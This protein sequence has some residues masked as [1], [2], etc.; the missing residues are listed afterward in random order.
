MGVKIRSKGNERDKHIHRVVLIAMLPMLA[1]SLPVHAGTITDNF[2]SYAVG[3]TFPALQWSDVGAVLPEPPVAPLPSATVI[4][5]TDA[6]GNATQ[7]LSTVGALAASKGIFAPVPVSLNY[8]LAADVRVDRY[9]DHSDSTT[10][11]WA[12]QLTFAQV[13]I[14][15]F[16]TTPQAGIYASSLTQGWRLFLISSNGGAAFADI[17]LGAA[18]NTDTWYRLELTL[19]VNTGAFHSRVSDIAKAQLLIDRTDVITNWQPQDARFDSFAFFGGELSPDDTVGNIGIVDNV[20][21]V[22]T[23]V[24]EPG[25][26]F[27]LT[28]GLACL[29]VSGWWARTRWARRIGNTK[30]DLVSPANSRVSRR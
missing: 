5:T 11:D 25:T 1:H 6:F 2:E 24:P 17:D 30:Q 18:A 20:N 26:V 22:A 21:I 28:T 19:D 12:M 23:P 9:S 8:S 16:A 14:R 7:A 29:F 13:G 15:N 10:S 3:T 4:T 27:L